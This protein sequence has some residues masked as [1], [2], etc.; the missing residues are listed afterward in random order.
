MKAKLKTKS[1]AEIADPKTVVYHFKICLLNISP[2]IY[3]RFKVKGDIHIAELHHLIQIVMGWD[4]VHLHSFNIWGRTYGI[5]RSGGVM[6]YDNPCKIFIGDLGFRVGDTFTYDY[7]FG[8]NWEHEIRVEKIEEPSSTY[9][10]PSCTEGKRAC[11]PEDC[12][13]PHL[14]DN[15]I[16]NQSIWIRETYWDFLDCIE[17]GRLPEI[18]TDDVPYWYLKHKSEYFDKAKINRAIKKLYQEKG[19]DR[20]WLDLQDYYDYLADE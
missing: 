3:R 9:T 10:Y 20:F 7:D 14:Y 2:M 17:E 15:A 5:Y 12:G 1:G 13:G 16:T 4:N 18:D 8:D 6:F 11:P 19:D